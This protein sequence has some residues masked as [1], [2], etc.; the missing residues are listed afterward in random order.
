MGYENM[1]HINKNP[2]PNMVGMCANAEKALIMKDMGNGHMRPLIWGSVI[3]LVSGE[4]EGL[5]AS[6]TMADVFVE[7]CV[8]S[9]SDPDFRITKDVVEHTVKVSTVSGTVSEET[10]IDVMVFM[11]AAVAVDINDYTGQRGYLRGNF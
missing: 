6:G 3:T 8:Y 4:S 5:V 1:D 10:S 2:V 11:S 7:S 9:L